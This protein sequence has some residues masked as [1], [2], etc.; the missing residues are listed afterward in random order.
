MVVN[1][2]PFYYNRLLRF[3]LLEGTNMHLQ[4]LRTVQQ[5][6]SKLFSDDDDA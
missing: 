5:A 3:F 2:T 1:N 6:Q 4:S